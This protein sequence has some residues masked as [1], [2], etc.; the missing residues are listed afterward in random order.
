MDQLAF[1]LILLVST[2]DAAEEAFDDPGTQGGIFIVPEER[3]FQ[4]FEH[5]CPVAGAPEDQ[6]FL[7]WEE[8]PEYLFLQ[9]F[10][11]R[12]GA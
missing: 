5:D 7:F 10:A 2:A 1:G 3:G 6:G 11:E 12:L 4:F 8:F 9:A